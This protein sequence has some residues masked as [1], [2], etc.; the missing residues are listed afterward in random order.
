M[1]GVGVV[2]RRVHDGASSA[3]GRRLALEAAQAL[4]GQ[5]RADLDLVVVVAVVGSGRF[6]RVA[7][8]E[9]LDAGE[10]ARQ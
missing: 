10:V 6:H 8:R 9:S 2:A 1:A 4:L 3:R 7:D 5:R